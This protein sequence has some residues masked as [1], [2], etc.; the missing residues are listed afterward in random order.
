MDIARAVL[1]EPSVSYQDVANRFGVSRQRVG[2]IVKRMGI[3]RR[4]GNEVS[5]KS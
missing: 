5:E 4:V 3:Q 2:A 1:L